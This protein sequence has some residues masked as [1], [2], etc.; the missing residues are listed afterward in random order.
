MEHWRGECAL[1]KL[2]FPS[3]TRALRA[4]FDIDTHC[5]HTLAAEHLYQTSRGNLADDRGMW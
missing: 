4:S 5:S 2:F 1:V 3:K